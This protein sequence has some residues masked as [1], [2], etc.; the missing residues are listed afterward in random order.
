L[1]IAGPRTPST[2]RI[3]AFTKPNWS[4]ITQSHVREL[5]CHPPSVRSAKKLAPSIRSLAGNRI[6][7]RRTAAT[8]ND[9]REPVGPDAADEE[10]QHLRQRAR[11]E[12]EAEVR[13]RAGQVE[14]GERE[15]DGCERVADE[16][17][18]PAEEGT[19]S[20]VRGAGR[21]TRGGSRRDPRRRVRR[22]SGDGAEGD[23]TPDLQSATL[24]LSQL[25]YGPLVPS[26]CSL[27]IEVVRPINAPLL[28][29]QRRRYSKLNRRAF[30]CQFDRDEE[31]T[32]EV[33][34]VRGDYIDFIGRVRGLLPACSSAAKCVAA[35]DKHL[36]ERGR[37]LA[38]DSQK[39]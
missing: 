24:A 4:T 34:R 27:E 36:L 18:R 11:R 23:R 19:G 32:V 12:D 7:A 6:I 38:L 1:A 29:V 3:I 22:G 25:S 31:A 2:P 14:D 26:K 37:P 30:L 33:H 21:V 17:G 13:L 15:R 9:A 28:V 16:R 20:C 8:R 35:Q 39:S 5:N 10:E